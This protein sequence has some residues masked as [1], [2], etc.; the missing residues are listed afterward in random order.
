MT[1]R[2]AVAAAA[3][4]LAAAPLAAQPT[5]AALP[6]SGT[7][8]RIDLVGPGR[9]VGTLVAREPDRWVVARERGD[10][11]TVV[12]RD[13]QDLD[14]SRGRRSAGQA[15]WR[16]AGIGA[17]VGGSLTAGGFAILAATGDIDCNDCFIPPALVVG[18]L[19]T[20]LTIGT[21]LVGGIIGSF[22]RDRWER[23]VLPESARV[24]IAPIPGG[25]AVALQIAWPR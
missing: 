24:G 3:L 10:T 25:A 18:V 2:P 11:V 12:L 17:L 6:D 9:V 20:G 5:L 15:F 14:V 19:G 21:T 13:A 4:L 16:G 23:V 7:R 8:V 22:A 1:H